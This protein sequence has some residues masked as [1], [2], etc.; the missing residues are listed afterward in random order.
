MTKPPF[1]AHSP[2][3]VITRLTRDLPSL[4]PTSGEER[5]QIKF[6]MTKLDKSPLLGCFVIGRE[7][8]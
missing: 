3:S 6:T 1:G 2:S 5:R 8:Y 4:K 7:I